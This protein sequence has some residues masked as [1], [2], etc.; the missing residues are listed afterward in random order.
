MPI[1]IN[2]FIRLTAAF[3]LATLLVSCKASKTYKEA[4][5]VQDIAHYERFVAQFPKNKNVPAANAKLFA[6]YEERDWTIANKQGTAI[7]ITQF[8]TK[9]PNSSKREEAEKR[10]SKLVEEAD[11]RNAYTTNTIRSYEDFLAKHPGSANRFDARTRI[12]GLREND[13]WQAAVAKNSI[14]GY[15]DF[16]AFHSKSSFVKAAQSRILNLKDKRDWSIAQSTNSA[17]AYENYLRLYPAGM[18]AMEAGTKLEEIRVQRPAWEAAKLQNNYGGYVDFVAK[19]P[20]SAYAFAGQQK[21]DSIEMAA[22]NVAKQ[23]N[24]ERA[25]QQFLET[26]P[27]SKLRSDAVY[28]ISSMEEVEWSNAKAKQT[29]TGVRVYLSKYPNG[30][31]ASPAND[32][33]KELVQ[34]E[35]VKRR[36]T[37]AGYLAF[38]DA[39]WASPFVPVA[40]H[41]MDSIVSAAY[42]KASSVNTAKAM[43]DF[44]QKYPDSQWESVAVMRLEQMDLQS[45]QKADRLGTLTSYRSYLNEF[46]SGGYKEEA[47]ERIQSIVDPW[48]GWERK[49]YITGDSPDCD[50]VGNIYDRGLDNYL[51]VKVGYST[52]VAIKIMEQYTNE[53]VRFVYVRAGSTFQMKNVPEGRY[54]LKIAYGQEAVE[55]IINGKCE[56]KFK[57]NA[58]YEK[59]EDIL[60][61]NVVKTWNGEQIPY[62][63]LFLDVVTGQGNTFDS[64][65]IS[66]VEF[67]R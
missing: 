60:D 22:F 9:Y 55:K 41:R 12:D 43:R 34:W 58:L 56:F 45:W 7:A 35:E 38:M 61:F 20:R 15:E 50:N 36:N 48:Y 32:L 17:T 28:A 37:Y 39:N 33:L 24:T 51:Q 47:N 5:K 63:E 23:S 57:K 54:Y 42:E 2:N 64:D 6:L 4:L 53:C 14:E 1:S 44:I 29:S 31:Y 16:V 46:P 66:E 11:W 65:R 21:V 40:K 30:K 26:F 59:G 62:F 8:L 49:S 18:H 13:A 25:Y 52:D 19:F 27:N 10:R 3:V 67:N